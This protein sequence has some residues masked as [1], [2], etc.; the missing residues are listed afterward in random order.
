MRKNR[1][2]KR[3]VLPDPIFGS[4]IITK[5]INIVMYD[6]KKGLA[7]HIVYGALDLVEKKTKQKGI[8]VFNKALNNIMP[9][10]ELKVRRVAGSN[11]QVPTP[12]NN[13]RKIVLGLRWL[14]LYARNRNG[15][16]MQEKLAAEIIDASNN[17]GNAVKKKED[18]HKM[19]EANKAFTH[20]RF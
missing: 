10:I 15:K 19:A 2:T 14:I 16:S 20:L 13:D 7:Q 1:A 12:V 3:Q 17:I 5:V 6:G 11:Y 8:D 18:T 9:E 4:R